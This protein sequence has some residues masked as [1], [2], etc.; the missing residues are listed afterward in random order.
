MEK[1]NNSPYGELPRVYRQVTKEF[2]NTEGTEIEKDIMEFTNRA[3]T[4]RYT[5]RLKKIAIQALI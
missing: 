3:P 1:Q 4:H 5:T 2:N